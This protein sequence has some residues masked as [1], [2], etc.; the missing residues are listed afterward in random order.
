MIIQKHPFGFSLLGEQ[1]VESIHHKIKTIDHR[2]IGI[3]DPAKRLL[4]TIEEH[5]L[6]T[7]PEIRVDVPPIKKR[8][9]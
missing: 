1:G 8:K 6:H 5:H 3:N 9:Q 7:L 4:A 2:F